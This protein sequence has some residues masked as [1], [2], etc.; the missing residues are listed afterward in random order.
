MARVSR[1]G[2]G[3]AGL[4]DT[5]AALAPVLAPWSPGG[6]A[7]PGALAVPATRVGD[8]EIQL[9]HDE[10]LAALFGELAGRAGGGAGAP[11]A[12]GERWRVV[13]RA[14]AHIDACGEASVRIDELCVAACTSLSGLERAFREVYGVGPRRFL[15]LR[16]LAAVR[17]ALLR[18]QRGASVTDIAT[19]FGFFHL[20]RFSCEYRLMYGERPSQTRRAVDASP[21]R[22]PQIDSSTITGA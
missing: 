5:L 4:R 2:A 12:P 1:K 21:G 19:R 20:G 18:G 17:R 13:R 9:A 14:E 11:S 8:A 10:L 15:M 16:R 3:G 6:S 22:A 7:A